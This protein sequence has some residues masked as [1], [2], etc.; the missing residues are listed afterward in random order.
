MKGPD[1]RLKCIPLGGDRS[2]T[3]WSLHNHEKRSR[4]NAQKIVAGERHS[5][6][7]NSTPEQGKSSTAGGGGREVKPHTVLRRKLLHNGYTPLPEDDK[8]SPIKG[9]NTADVDEAAID[10]W[11][12]FRAKTGTAFR[13]QDDLM[14]LDFDVDDPEAMALIASRVLHYLNLTPDELPRVLRRTGSGAK[15]AW[16]FLIDTPFPRYASHTWSK[17]GEEKGHRLE[18]FGGLS[19]ATSARSAR[20]QSTLIRAKS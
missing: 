9:W 19:R 1:E 6:A 20:T 7:T 5:P 4:A 8:V 10:K 13:L 16:F 17:P 3:F 15:E 12:R 14:V 11:D 18:A 2:S